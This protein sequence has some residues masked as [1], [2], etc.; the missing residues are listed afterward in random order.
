MKQHRRQ[1]MAGGGGR[2]FCVGGRSSLMAVVSYGF[3]L[4]VSFMQQVVYPFTPTPTSTANNAPMLLLPPERSC[5]SF[6]QA[7]SSKKDHRGTTSS[8]ST[9]TSSSLSM[10]GMWSSD[11]ELQGSDRIKACV[12]YLLPLMDGDQFGHYI[13]YSRFPILGEINDFLLGPLV[14]A[15][16]KIPFLGVG[17]FVLLTL[18]TRFNTDINRNVRFSAQQAALIDV[19]LIVPELIAGIFQGDQQLPRYIVEPCNN[20]VWYVSNIEWLASDGSILSFYT[21]LFGSF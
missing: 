6:V 16:H 8:R 18:G 21:S 11:D 9:S 2:T 14:H 20:F 5:R 10:S 1:R 15:N 4:A 12:P 13:L 3:L 17:F 7:R 19:G